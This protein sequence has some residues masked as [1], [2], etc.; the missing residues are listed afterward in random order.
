MLA[1]VATAFQRSLSRTMV[2]RNS[3]VLVERGS[4]L[5]AC[6]KAARKARLVELEPR[7]VDVT[8]QRWEAYT[9][10]VAM[11]EANG[12]SFAQTK[13]ERLLRTA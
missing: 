6:E 7:F 3:L 9:G 13:Q 10:R 2:S 12:E 11:L 4:T 1:L 8:V 5:I